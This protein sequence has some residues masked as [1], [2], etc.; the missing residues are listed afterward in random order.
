M[1]QG[2]FGLILKCTTGFYA[3]SLLPILLHFQGPQISPLH[4]LT[5]IFLHHQMLVAAVKQ[6][7]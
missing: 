5:V 2:T 1:K 7:K 4:S 6:I 3:A